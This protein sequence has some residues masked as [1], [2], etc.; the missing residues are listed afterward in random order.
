MPDKIPMEYMERGKLRDLARYLCEHPFSHKTIREAASAMM[1][2]YRRSTD[3]KKCC[4]C[5][6]LL[7]MDGACMCDWCDEH[8][9]R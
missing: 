5:D 8:Y 2:L 9:G 6:K 7:P 1:K 4:H 3:Y